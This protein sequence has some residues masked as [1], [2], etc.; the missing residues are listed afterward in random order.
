MTVLFADADLFEVSADDE[1]M[2]WNVMQTRTLKFSVA[3]MLALI[4]FVQFV[5]V[6][7]N[8]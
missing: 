6:Y 5:G 4:A 1:H 2:I 3:F 7:A 8:F